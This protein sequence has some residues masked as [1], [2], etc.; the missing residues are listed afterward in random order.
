M[1][2]ML[3]LRHGWLIPAALSALVLIAAAGYAVRT[4]AFDEQRER[5][6]GGAYRSSI[7]V[8][9]D[10]E[11]HDG[12]GEE[13]EDHADA[14]RGSEQGEGRKAESSEAAESA[15][16]QPLAR[17]SAEQA[18]DAALAQ[19]GGTAEAVALENEDGNLVY[20][21]KVKTTGGQREVKVDAGDGRV[22]HVGADGD[23]ER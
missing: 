15:R 11:K 1:K 7:Q 14:D 19:V 4:M 2:K 3:N 13:A 5:Q 10:Q 23:D 8:P 16:L 6:E 9:D 20:S 22:L 18:R 12:E 17:I 21:V